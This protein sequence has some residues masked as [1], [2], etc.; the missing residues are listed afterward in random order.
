MKTDEVCT[1]NNWIFNFSYYKGNIIFLFYCITFLLNINI[2]SS[3]LMTSSSYIKH[4]HKNLIY[5]VMNC[6]L[7]RTNYF[8]L[9]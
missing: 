2:H 8:T 7:N 1:K 6:L 3:Y 5:K 4:S 9:L